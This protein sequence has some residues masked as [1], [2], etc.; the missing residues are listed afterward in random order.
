MR[1]KW[2]TDTHNKSES[3]KC[4][5]HHPGDSVALVLRTVI[6]WCLSHTTL[7]SLVCQLQC[8]KT[9]SFQHPFPYPRSLGPY[10]FFHKSVFPCLCDKLNSLSLR[11]LRPWSITPSNHTSK[12]TLP[13]LPL[14]DFSEGEL[15]RG[16]CKPDTRSLIPWTHQGGRELTSDLHIFMWHSCLPPL[17]RNSAVL[18]IHWWVFAIF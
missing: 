17:I 12:M 16:L 13:P 6:T 18:S 2:L 8:A 11:N 7:H 10:T 5:S 14:P 1:T 4:L 3:V 9:P 15:P